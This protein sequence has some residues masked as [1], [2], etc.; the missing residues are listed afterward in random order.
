[1]LVPKLPNASRQ[2]LGR[3]SYVD[4]NPWQDSQAKYFT[5][6]EADLAGDLNMEGKTLMVSSFCPGSL[7][8]AKYSLRD[9]PET[10][11]N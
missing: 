1:M 11:G 10:K 6:W 5:T 2:I 8:T 9:L 4:D 3:H 7:L